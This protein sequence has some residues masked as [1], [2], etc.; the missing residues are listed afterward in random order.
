MKK[1]IFEKVALKAYQGAM[2]GG[3]IG[4]I[5]AGIDYLYSRK[6]EGDQKKELQRKATQ[7]L[8]LGGIGAG[9]GYGGVKL[10]NEY[11]GI[12]TNLDNTVSKVNN[13]ADNVDKKLHPIKTFKNWLKTK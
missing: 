3:A 4:S 9:L 10:H 13:I 7:K 6:A 1:E 12:K 11:K 5:P 2:I 8:L